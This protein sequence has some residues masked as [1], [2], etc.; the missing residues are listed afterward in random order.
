MGK[1]LLAGVQ[2]GGDGHGVESALLQTRCFCVELRASVGQ[3]S[4]SNGFDL[5]RG[6]R[7]DKAA[8]LV[9]FRFDVPL[10]WRA[11]SHNVVRNESRNVVDE[12]CFVG[13]RA[14][15]NSRSGI[16]FLHLTRII[17]GNVVSWLHED[18]R[19]GRKGGLEGNSASSSCVHHN[20]VPVAG[21][22]VTSGAVA[23]ADPARA[24]RILRG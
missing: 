4:I 13:M 19:A 8:T 11:G 3:T 5:R 22:A 16:S 12:W 6:R 20:S 15:S 24:G 14:F 1:R 7:H 10:P 9:L 17:S 21:S 2:K 23:P 18:V